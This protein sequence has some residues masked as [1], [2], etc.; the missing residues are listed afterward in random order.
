M[1]LR[2]D[3][4]N[5]SQEGEE[6]VTNH[7][8]NARV[9]IYVDAANLEMNGGYGIQYD[10]LRE[11]ACRDAAEA[12]R[13]NVYLPYDEERARTDRS[14]KRKKDNFFASLREYGFKVIQKKVKWYRDDKHFGF[15]TQLDGSDVFFHKSSVDASLDQIQEN[16]AVW[17]EVEATDRGP[18]AINVHLRE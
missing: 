2:R 16:T 14:Y 15:I 12:I 10:V 11:F 5:S 13:L 4:A 18:Q 8:S 7:K 1:V 9:G 3:I 6:S 17:Y